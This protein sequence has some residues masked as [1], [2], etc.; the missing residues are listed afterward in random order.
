MEA[1]F[2]DSCDDVLKTEGGFVDNPHDPG[3]AT[4]LGVTILTAKRLNLDVNHDGKINVLDIRDLKPSDAAVV[5]RTEY[6][7]KVKGD[8]LPAGLDYAVF[9]FAVNS[10]PGRAAMFLQRELGVSVDGAIGPKTLAAVSGKPVAGLIDGLCDARLAY[11]KRL[12]T[13]STFGKGW[14]NR[15]RSVR[16]AAHAMAEKSM[17][18]N[19]SAGAPVQPVAPAGGLLAAL[20]AIL[21]AIFGVK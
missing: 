13:W 9:D 14:S 3:G 10:G 4:N 17:A 2:K 11:L 6:W 20:L 8:S 5:Y 12:G 1:N 18:A 7:N 21:K 19:P 16:A 15:V